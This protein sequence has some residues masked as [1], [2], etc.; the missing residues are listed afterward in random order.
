MLQGHGV[1]LKSRVQVGLRWMAGI[2]RL[3]EK[4]QIGQFQGP[5]YSGDAAYQR[6]ICLPLIRRMKEH[7][8]EK[9]NGGTEQDQAKARFP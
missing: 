7:R 4:A 8:S 6:D 3:R 9:Q 2:A 1:I 5:G